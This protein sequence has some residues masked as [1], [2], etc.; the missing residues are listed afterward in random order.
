MAANWVP[1]LFN[2]TIMYEITRDNLTK[3]LF[4]TTLG[5]LEIFLDLH[6]TRRMLQ[7]REIRPQSVGD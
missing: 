5:Y 7:I 1:S 2:E 6:S 4:I 3:C